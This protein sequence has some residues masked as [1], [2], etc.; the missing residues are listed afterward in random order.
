[1]PVLP[2]LL[3]V[4]ALLKAEVGPLPYSRWSFW[5]SKTAPARLLKIAPLLNDSEP[6]LVQVAVPALFRVL[7][8]RYLLLSP[9]M[10][11]PP[12]AR[13][14][15]EPLNVPPVQLNSPLMVRSVLPERVPP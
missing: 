14:V 15:P 9:L 11:S 13:T 1:M 12:L 2:D 8:S 5:A 6:A 4:P 3:K 7:P 10:V